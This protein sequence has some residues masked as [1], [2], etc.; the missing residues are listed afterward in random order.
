MLAKTVLETVLESIS[1]AVHVLPKQFPKHARSSPQS[2]PRPPV[3]P[4]QI[5][6]AQLNQAP[7]LVQAASPGAQFSR[8]HHRR[9]AAL[10]REYGGV[11]LKQSLTS[12]YN[13]HAP[14]NSLHNS[15]AQ[16]VCK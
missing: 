11:I 4:P 12:P 5:V 7:T 13:S 3:Q 6:P 9:D 2:S 15:L 1:E 16:I 10:E 8:Y 14:K